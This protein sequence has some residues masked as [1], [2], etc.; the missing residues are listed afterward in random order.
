MM[1]EL[2]IM[3]D[4]QAVT[5]SLKVAEIFEKRHDH[6]I[7]DISN[8]SKDVPNFGEMFVQSYEPDSYGR[9][10]KMFYMNRDGFTLL[11]MGFTG[12]KA[13][14]FKLKY[15][16]AFNKM[17]KQIIDKSLQVSNN[18]DDFKRASLLYK[19]ANLTSDEELKEK[20]LKSTYELV[21]GKSIEKPKKTDYQKLYEAVNE[22]Y[23]ES[24]GDN[25]KA[26]IRFIRV[27]K[28]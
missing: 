4:K 17:E 15:I 9:N 14:E 7:R 19:I 13:M 25:L 22:R 26:V 8:L 10:R 28:G 18:V 3:H 5:T 16:D 21:T 1:N 20:S 23:G 11:A 24:V 27:W 12:S 2:V 6:I